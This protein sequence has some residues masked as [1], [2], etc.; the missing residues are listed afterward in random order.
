MKERFEE[1]ILGVFHLWGYSQVTTP[2][3]EYLHVL[4]KGLDEIG[5][6]R[7]IT[8]I[9]PAGGDKPLALRS[10]VTP[11]IARIAATTLKNRP[12]PLRLSYAETVF[13]RSPQGD[14]KRM[15]VYQAGAELIGV[16]SPEA[17]AEM[18]AMGIESLSRLGYNTD[19]IKVAVSHVG[20]VKALIE[21]ANLSAEEKSDVKEALTK[22]DTK[23]LMEVLEKTGAK[24]S[25]RETLE[26]LP[27]LFGEVDI[28]EN[29]P[30]P[31][32]E[33]KNAIE[34]VKEVVSVMKLYGLENRIT[35]DLSEIRGFGYYTGLTFEAFVKGLPKRVFFRWKI[36]HP[37]IIVW[38]GYARNRV[39]YRY[40]SSPGNQFHNRL[41][42]S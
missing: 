19:D 39:R 14:R 31:N 18:I 4:S 2:S 33:A 28:L 21:D 17:D 40:R 9:D 6:K 38:R 24:N 37:F 5:K 8:F 23:A 41:D 10:D 3:V 25:A 11:Q 34:N 36:R 30:T 15:E 12:A 7:V 1:T 29:A 16:D 26:A 27:G 22:K 13:R 35:I 42:F 20:Y 32:S